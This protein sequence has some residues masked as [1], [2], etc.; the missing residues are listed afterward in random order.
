MID[1]RRAAGLAACVAAGCLWACG[2][3]RVA[4]PPGGPGTTLT[5]LLPDSE[6]G[7]VGRAVVSTPNGSGT[8][9]LSSARESTSASANSPP[10]PAVVLSDADVQRLFG[11]ALSA[12]PPPPQRFTF[13]F[14]FE[15]D[16]LTD[17]SRALVPDILAAVKG[18]PSPEVVVV[19][20]TDTTGSTASNF[21]LGLKRANMV[22]NLLI[23]AGMDAGAIDITSLGESDLI[24]Q[25]ADD[26]AEPRNRRVEI[27]VK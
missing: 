16:E 13:Y 11:P 7:A 27:V 17:E 4:P 19:G 1:G 25:T 14:K 22:G 10:S 20:H 24:V 2:P 6:S 23:Q 26:V 15:S 3:K 5:V 21:E 12:L 18:R 8:V 9:E